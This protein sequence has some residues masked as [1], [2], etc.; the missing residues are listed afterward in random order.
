MKKKLKQDFFETKLSVCFEVRAME[1]FCA[2]VLQS[3]NIKHCYQTGNNRT[4]QVIPVED[5]YYG[6]DI[7]RTSGP[8]AIWKNKQG[9]KSEWRKILKWLIEQ[10]ITA[11]Q[12]HKYTSHCR[13]M[14][15]PQAA[16]FPY[17]RFILLNGESLYAGV[18]FITFFRT[19]RSCSDSFSYRIC[20]CVHIRQ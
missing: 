12:I 7:S 15:K 18:F 13:C 8:E 3:P 2:V 1:N 9:M 5:R 11:T 19:V 6:I 20:S 17:L 10:V 14:D 16:A 4:A